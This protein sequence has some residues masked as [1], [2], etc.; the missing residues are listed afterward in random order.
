MLSTAG[1]AQSR[2]RRLRAAT[3]RARRIAEDLASPEFPFEG[4]N[5]VVPAGPAD[6]GAAVNSEE[7]TD[8]SASED[9]GP[10]SPVAPVSSNSLSDENSPEP[11]IQITSPAVPN[12]AETS[13]VNGTLDSEEVDPSGTC[14]PDRNSWVSF[15]YLISL[16]EDD[17]F[18]SPLLRGELDLEGSANNFQPAINSEEGK[19]VATRRSLYDPELQSLSV[20]KAENR[21]MNCSAEIGSRIIRRENDMSAEDEAPASSLAAPTQ[22]PSHLRPEHSDI[23]IQLTPPSPPSSI[24]SSESNRFTQTREMNW[25]TSHRRTHR[26][27][28]SYFSATS[29]RPGL[30]GRQADGLGVTISAKALSRYLSNGCQPAGDEAG[31]SQ[32]LV[33]V[34]PAG[35]MPFETPKALVEREVNV[36]NTPPEIQAFSAA[37]SSRPNAIAAQTVTDSADSFDNSFP[38][39]SQI[40]GPTTAYVDSA[41]ES[42]NAGVTW[43]AVGEVEPSSDAAPIQ[44]PGRRSSEAFASRP[45]RQQALTFTSRITSSLREWGNAASR[46]LAGRRTANVEGAGTSNAHLDPW[47]GFVPPRGPSPDPTPDDDIEPPKSNIWNIYVKLD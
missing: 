22:S 38:A 10:S 39:T 32:H 35:R 43:S 20:A 24:K 9:A 6:D 18:F 37:R 26:R 4:L 46:L 19:S 21:S 30:V 1:L 36:Q 8:S 41:G 5:V 14:S 28:V 11:T 12:A 42:I 44:S 23:V 15:E 2:R 47:E 33:D 7:D 16:F 25:Y 27:G 31:A 40:S 34:P 45:I 3:I 13:E 29:D 17:C